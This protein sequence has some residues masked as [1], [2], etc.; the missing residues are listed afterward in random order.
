MVVKIYSLYNKL[1]P[2][3][4]ELYSMQKY[5]ELQSLDYFSKKLNNLIIKNKLINKKTV[6]FVGVKYPYSKRYKKNFV[7]LTEKIHNLNKL[8]LVYGFYHYNYDP[9]FFY[10]NS[11]KRKAAM[12][13]LSKSDEIK[14]NNY[15]FIVIEDSIITGTTK[16][17]IIKSLK[18]ITKKISFV[19]IIDLRKEKTIE[20]NINDNYFVKSGIKGLIKLLNTIDYTPTT[21]MLR[22]IGLLKKEDLNYLLKRIS[23]PKDII[24]SY[25]SYTNKSL[26]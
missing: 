18:K 2:K 20:K 16:S 11:E 5:G 25:K 23:N 14:Y 24:K 12:P 6:L 15:H 19:S 7:I 17:I 10:D 4:K 22:T 13:K 26:I 8:S 21:Q 1:S 9:K 3:I